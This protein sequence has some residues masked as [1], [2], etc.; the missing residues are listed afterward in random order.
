[1][2]GELARYDDSDS[3]KLAKISKGN[4]DA[5]GSNLP[6][7]GAITIHDDALEGSAP[8][9]RGQY[10]YR[11]ISQQPITITHQ[12]QEALRFIEQACGWLHEQT[13]RDVLKVDASL[14]R[15][16]ESKQATTAGANTEMDV[17]DAYWAEHEP[18]VEQYSSEF[19]RDNAF[20][21]AS[22]PMTVG[23]SYE[24]IPLETTTQNEPIETQAGPDADSPP[25]ST[26]SDS[27]LE[28]AA[29]HEAALMGEDVEYLHYNAFADYQ[30]AEERKPISSS[31][32]YSNAHT[33]LAET[34][35]LY[36]SPSP[37]D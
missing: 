17:S 30:V 11:Q 14:A 19:Y 27:M 20:D 31:Y 7:G 35:L 34:C 9:D 26:Y 1:M 4:F 37:R 5:L 25:L 12:S 16:V 6:L 10:L 36:T 3:S 28:A 32:N 24:E 18:D 2:P 21:K 22:E 23:T 29:A 15:V 33:D 13:R 8:S